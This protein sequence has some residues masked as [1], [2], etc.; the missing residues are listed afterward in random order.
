MGEQGAF[1]KIGRHGVPYRDP[2]ER[3]KDFEEFMIRRPDDE[4]AAQGA[5]QSL[6]VNSGKLFVASSRSCASRQRPVRTRSFQSG[7]RLP[8]GQASLQNGTPQ[9]MHRLAWRLSSGSGI[10]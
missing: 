10:T 4:L 1:L 3:A 9:P 5:G 8:S 7:I 2:A 6:P